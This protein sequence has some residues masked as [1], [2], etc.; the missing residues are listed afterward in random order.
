MVGHSQQSKTAVGLFDKTA[1]SA[2]Q[3]ESKRSKTGRTR[4]TVQDVWWT[5]SPVKTRVQNE[6]KTCKTLSTEQHFQRSKTSPRRVHDTDAEQVQVDQDTFRRTLFNRTP[7]SI[8]GVQA[9][10]YKSASTGL[11]YWDTFDDPRRV[12]VAVASVISGYSRTAIHIYVF[13]GNIKWQ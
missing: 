7:S 5:F 13:L 3:N 9:V 12:A 8:Q 1:V 2:V 11:F 4:S 10:Q 6:S